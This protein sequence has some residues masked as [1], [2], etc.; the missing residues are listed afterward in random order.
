MGELDATIRAQ[1]ETP[2]GPS[3][4]RMAIVILAIVVVG[5]AGWFLGAWR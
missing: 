5:V 4:A 2:Y 3:N 1:G